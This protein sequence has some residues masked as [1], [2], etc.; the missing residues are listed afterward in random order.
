MG[1]N[2]WAD[3]AAPYY[4]L[5]PAPLPQ[6]GEGGVY[7]FFYPRPLGGRGLPAAGVFI[8]RGGTGEG[9]DN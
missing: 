4:P 5:T 9:V 3:F 2:R 6:R 8:S 1:S 7:S